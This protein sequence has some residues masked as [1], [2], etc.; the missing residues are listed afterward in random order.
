MSSCGD[1]VQEKHSEASTTARLLSAELRERM[2][3]GAE[4]STADSSAHSGQNGCA[5]GACFNDRSRSNSLKRSREEFSVPAAP[6]RLDVTAGPSSGH[7]Y[8][9]DEGLTEVR[10]PSPCTA[11][12]FEVANCF[13]LIHHGTRKPV[14]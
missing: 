11:I 12:Y 8:T 4:A 6:I 10:Q 2:Q 1:V 9:L 14:S 3:S 13:Y 5:A 7:S